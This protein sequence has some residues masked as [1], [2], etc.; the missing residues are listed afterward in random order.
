MDWKRLTLVLGAAVLVLA[1]G[2]AFGL[3]VLRAHPTPGSAPRRA[4]APCAH[5]PVSRALVAKNQ[6]LKSFR[7]HLVS[8]ACEGDWAAAAI[9]ARSVGHGEAFLHRDSSGWVSDQVN[10]GIYECSDLPKAFVAPVPP[11]ALALRL[12]RRVGLC[13]ATNRSSSPAPPPSPA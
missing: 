2:G 5:G 9:Y 4:Q 8:Y 13:R 10:G 11:Q 7:W 6:Q 12:F 1:A 3:Y